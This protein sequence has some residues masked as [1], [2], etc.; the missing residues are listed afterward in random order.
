[1]RALPVLSHLSF[2]FV[3]LPQ[4][5]TTQQ[6]NNRKQRLI[7][8][9][10]WALLHSFWPIF[11][12]RA[13][14]VRL[15]TNIPSFAGIS[16]FVSESVPLSSFSIPISTAIVTSIRASQPSSPYVSASSLLTYKMKG[17][18]KKI[19]ILVFVNSLFRCFSS[20]CLHPCAHRH[21]S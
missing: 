14:S 15:V 3:L 21:T 10:P 4:R 16:P 2:L 9:L 18:E 6:T 7:R 11:V 20:S 13:P 8:S 19:T 1:M 5:N 12:P 17:K